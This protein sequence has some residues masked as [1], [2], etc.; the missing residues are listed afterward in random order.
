MKVNEYQEKAMS[1]C[2]AS[3]NNFAYMFNNLL[4]EVGELVEKVNHHVGGNLNLCETE[5]DLR[6]YSVL[7]KAVRK[8]PDTLLA[9]HERDFYQVV[10][11]DLKG[12]ALLRKELGDIAWQLAGLCSVLGLS[13]EDVLQENLNKLASRKERGTIDGNGDDR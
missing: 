1:T 3:S 9:E 12:D 5:D 6:G 7:A 2:M 10:I 11:N 4:G 8:K 13:L